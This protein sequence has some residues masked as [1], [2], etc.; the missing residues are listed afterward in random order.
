M[1][2]NLLYYYTLMNT[3]FVLYNLAV[4]ILSYLFSTENVINECYLKP[5]TKNKKG[6]P[7]MEEK[8]KVRRENHDL[9]D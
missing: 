1:N 4:V 5:K 2:C 9:I 3:S 7:K 6:K 8:N